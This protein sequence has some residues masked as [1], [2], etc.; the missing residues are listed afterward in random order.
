MYIGKTTAVK[1]GELRMAVLMDYT[2]SL[3]SIFIDGDHPFTNPQ[4]KLSCLDEQV[5][6]SQ[7]FHCEGLLL[8]ILEEDDPKVVVWNP[9]LGQTRSIESR[10]SHRPHGW[11]SWD[12]FSYALGYEDKKSCRKLKFLRFIDK[13][14]DK[15]SNSG[16]ILASNLKPIGN[17]GHH[18]KRGQLWEQHPRSGPECGTFIINTP[19]HA[20]RSSSEAWAIVGTTSTGWPRIDCSDTMTN[21]IEG[22][23]LEYSSMWLHGLHF[24]N[25]LQ[26][27]TILG[28]PCSPRYLQYS[29][30]RQR[31]TRNA[32]SAVTMRNTYVVDNH[33]EDGNTRNT[34]WPASQRNSEDE[35]D[36]HI[37]CFDFTSERFGPLLRLPFDA[38]DDDYVTLSCVREEKLAVSLTHNEVKPYEIDIWISTKIEAELEVLWSKFLTVDTAPNFYMIPRKS[39]FIDDEKKVVMGLEDYHKTFNILERMATLE[40]WISENVPTETVGNMHALM[41]QV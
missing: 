23:S 19:P 17:R 25:G 31:W 39:F 26:W 21:L 32:K 41:F 6:I 9:Y 8:C 18:L 14:Y 38:G 2:L 1:E 40:N 16:Y 36:D 3:V 11:E 5:K 37:I 12:R 35:L 33:V 15:V 10:Y 29:P 20:Q 30:A 22:I 4:G 7:V 27:P 34:Y 24:I 28:S 13:S